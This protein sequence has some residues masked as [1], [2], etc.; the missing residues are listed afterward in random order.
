M[1]QEVA[2]GLGIKNTVNRRG[3]VREA[4]KEQASVLEKGK[5][6]VLG[7]YM[8]ASLAN[9]GELGQ[10]DLHD[11]YTTFVA[12]IFRSIRFGAPSAP[13]KANLVRFNFFKEMGAF[14]RDAAIGTYRVDFDRIPGASN[15]LSERIL[16]FR[17]NGDYD[18]VVA[19]VQRNGQMDATLQAD[20]PRLAAARIPVDVVFEQGTNV[21]GL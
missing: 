6:D 18:A 15:A 5:A 20:L 3:T 1:F 4:L 2:H 12:S 13:G 9:Q 19:F 17:D 7:L 21:L 16:R 14:T 11:Y 10:A 8:V